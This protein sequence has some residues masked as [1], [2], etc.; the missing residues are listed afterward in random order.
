MEEVHPLTD[1]ALDRRE[2]LARGGGAALALGLGAQALGVAEAATGIPEIVRMGAVELSRAIAA[3]RVSCAEVMSATLDHIAR[4]NPRV[5]AIVSLQDRDGLMAEARAR[6]AELAR[7][8]RLGPM[9]GMPQAIKDLAPARGIRLTMGSPILKDVVA[10]TDAIHVERV[11]RAGAIIIGKTNTP[12]FGLGSQTYNPVFGTT[13]NAY[14][15]SKTPGGSSGGAASALALRMLPVADGSDSGGSLRNPAAFS[16]LY[17]LRPSPGRVPAESDAF[18]LGFG[19]S[20]PLARSVADLGLLL[21]VQAGYDARAPLSNRQDPAQFAGPLRR[22]FKGTRVAWLGDGKGHLPF[23]PG[24]LELCR[25]ALKVFEGLGCTIEEAVPDFALERVWQSW[26]ALRAWQNG[27]ALKAY[28]QDP[29]KRALLKPE[30]RYEVESAMRLSGFDISDAA[31]TR[32]AWYQTMRRFSERYEFLLLPSAQVFPFDARTHWPAEIAGRKMDTYHRW[33][34]VCSLVTMTGA[35]ALNVPAGFGA[36][37]LPMGMQIVGR[38]QAE[39]GCLQLASAYE[40]ATGWV[41][42]RRPALLDT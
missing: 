29:A 24:V 26:I 9:H 11:K 20:G 13:L 28:Y 16:N 36:N 18:Q 21:S 7:G 23:E 40:E 27:A 42:K 12:E 1:Q 3:K 31:A 30:A 39:L 38:H 37:G 4:F 41:E 35:P 22:D 10:T 32:A 34:E 33:M 14:D 2:L 5:N 15:L 6:D 8:N 17:G 25:A 19:V